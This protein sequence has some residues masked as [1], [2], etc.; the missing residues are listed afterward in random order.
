[1]NDAVRNRFLR[2]TCKGQRSKSTTTIQ[3][4]KNQQVLLKRVHLEHRRTNIDQSTSE[5]QEQ[6]EEEIR[7]QNATRSP[8]PKKKKKTI[9][10]TSIQ[11]FF[12]SK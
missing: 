4:Q 11:S 7:R 12:S 1:M 6:E 2:S 5:E 10:Q 9:K 8:Q 3:A